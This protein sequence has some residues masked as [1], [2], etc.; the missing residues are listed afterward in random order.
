MTN[1][2]IAELTIEEF[3]NLI[4]DIVKE[5]ISDLLLDPDEGLEMRQDF[6]A[7]FKE[8]TNSFRTG[9]MDTKPAQEVAKDLGLEW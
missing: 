1:T 7:F 4:R 6:M 3:R 9:E 2:T 5:T 8:S